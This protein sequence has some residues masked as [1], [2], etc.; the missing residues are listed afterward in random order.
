MYEED[1]TVLGKEVEKYIANH[2]DLSGVQKNNLRINRW[3]TFH[4]ASAV[5]LSPE[6]SGHKK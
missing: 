1:Y 2:P 4:Q 3:R 5:G 6:K